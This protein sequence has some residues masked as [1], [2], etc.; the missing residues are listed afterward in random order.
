MSNQPPSKADHPCAAGRWLARRPDLGVLDRL[1]EDARLDIRAISGTSAG[2]MNAVA[3]ADGIARGGRE[4]A[5]EALARFWRAVSE[6]RGSRRS[7]VA[8]WTG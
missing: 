2:A 8:R 5:R 3:L 6:R 7:S 1:L 4:G